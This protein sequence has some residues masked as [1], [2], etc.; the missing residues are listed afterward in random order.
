MRRVLIP[1]GDA[2]KMGADLNYL[3]DKNLVSVRAWPDILD[4]MREF[5]RLLKGA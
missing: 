2:S 3:V 5:I 4:M 1:I